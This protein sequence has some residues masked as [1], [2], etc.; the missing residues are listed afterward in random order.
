MFF[1]FS[2]AQHNLNGGGSNDRLLSLLMPSRL[3]SWGSVNGNLKLD[4]IQEIKVGRSESLKKHA[5]KL[6]DQLCFSIITKDRTLDF[7][8]LVLSL[9]VLRVCSSF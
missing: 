6:S 3:L 9:F 7:E 2:V 8:V 5:T 4:Q 1:F